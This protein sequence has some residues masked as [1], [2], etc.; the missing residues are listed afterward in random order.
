MD[1]PIKISDQKY[2]RVD[3]RDS[4]HQKIIDSELLEKK[5][6]RYSDLPYYIV[7]ELIE[8]H[9]DLPLDSLIQERFY[10]PIG[11]NFSTYNPLDQF[12]KS[13]IIPTEEDNYFRFETVHGYVHD[14]G[15]AMQNGVGGHAGLFS[16]ANDVAKLMQ[17]FLQNGAYG[18]ERFLK[19]QTFDAFN[20]CY[21]CDEDNRRGVGFDK[22]Q[23]EEGGPTCDCVSM[24][25][26]GHSGFTGTLAWADPEEEI[27]YVFLS[28]RTYPDSK[29]NRLLE[30]N[31]RTEIQSLIYQAITD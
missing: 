27:I 11:A 9:Y 30:A 19:P 10:K 20:R 7:K 26:F 31:I 18:G 15:A 1:F 16:N 24:E 8:T 22:P 29:N 2:L 21:Y 3:F 13:Q 12:D 25:S 23:L 28:N 17:M 4:I 6:Y 14:M 5:E